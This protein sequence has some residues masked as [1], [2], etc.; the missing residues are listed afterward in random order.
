MIVYGRFSFVDEFGWPNREGRNRKLTVAN[1]RDAF[2]FEEKVVIAKKWLKHLSR[3]V[4]PYL[5]FLIT[6]EH[7]GTVNN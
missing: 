2:K 3:S 1:L 4:W 5:N 6:N 7:L